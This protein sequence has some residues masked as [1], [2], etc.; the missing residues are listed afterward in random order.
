MRPPQELSLRRGRTVIVSCLALWVAF[1]VAC[2]GP[3]AS[4]STCESFGGSCLVASG[5]NA[6]TEQ[7]G[8]TLPYACV[9]GTCCLPLPGSGTKAPPATTS[10]STGGGSGSSPPPVTDSGTAVDTSVDTTVTAP[11]DSGGAIDSTVASMDSGPPD[12]GMGDT[13]MPDT[14]V[15]DTNVADTNVA[16]TNMPDTGSTTVPTTCA[17][18]D[19]ATGCCAGNT[20]YYCLTTVTSMPCTGNKVCGWSSASNFYDC[21]APPGGPDP[22]GISPI[23]CQ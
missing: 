5:P 8:E 21:V 19:N 7:C 4:S 23:G 12:A 11:Q 17:G 20:L 22:S 3:S 10:T 16:D 13:A 2:V 14:N 18:A 1:G 6:S 15:A 9:S